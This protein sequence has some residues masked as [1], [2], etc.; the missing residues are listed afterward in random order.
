MG[1]HPPPPPK[2]PGIILPLGCT[3]L[4][5]RA[6]TVWGLLQPPFGELGLSIIHFVLV[7]TLAMIGCNLSLTT[8]TDVQWLVCLIYYTQLMKLGRSSVSRT[9]KEFYN[10]LH[11]FQWPSSLGQAQR[12]IQALPIILLK[13]CHQQPFNSHWSKRLP[14]NCIKKMPF[15]TCYRE[16]ISLAISEWRGSLERW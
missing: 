14:Y 16:F 2:V 4:S 1:S 3:I 15:K 12:V 10:G 11:Y 9:E 13:L 8:I 7:H 5:T 6:K